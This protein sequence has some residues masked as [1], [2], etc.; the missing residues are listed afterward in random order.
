M[1]AGNPSAYFCEMVSVPIAT[2]AKQSFEDKRVTKLE[3]GNEGLRVWAEARRRR[4]RSSV[5][6][7]GSGL[8]ATARL[9]G[10]QPGDEVV[11][12]AV[13]STNACPK[14]VPET[15]P[16]TGNSWMRPVRFK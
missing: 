6:L 9:G 8:T 3:L 5:A 2:S 15:Q 10:W 13:G 7:P 16:S 14:L 1:V 12:S 4:A 11:T